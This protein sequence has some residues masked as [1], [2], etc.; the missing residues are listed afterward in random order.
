MAKPTM[1]FEVKIIQKPTYLHAII[2]G[3]NT[4]QNVLAYV[5]NIRSECIARKCA[6]VLIEERLEGPRMGKMDIFETIG[7]AI[8]QAAGVFEAVAYVDVNA[9]DDSMNFAE[10]VARNRGIPM[11]VFSTVADADIWLKGD[12]RTE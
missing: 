7:R 1:K 3:D 5:E 8:I 9:V 12:E 10:T 6:R 2:T 4:K 11:R